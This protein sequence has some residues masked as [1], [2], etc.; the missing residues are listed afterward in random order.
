PLQIPDIDNRV[1]NLLLVTE[2]HFGRLSTSTTREAF[3]L[4]EA[5]F[6]KLRIHANKYAN[7]HTKLQLI[8]IFKS[9]KDNDM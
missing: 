9:I 5:N 3:Q 8:I 2:W 7:N 1:T 4:Y 6:L